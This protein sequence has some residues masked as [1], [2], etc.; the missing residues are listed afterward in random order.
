MNGVV[1]FA[2]N[3]P[4]FLD[5]RAEFLEQA[6][7]RVRKAYTLAQARHLLAEAHLHLAILDLRLEDDDDEKDIS[8]LILASEPAFRPVPKI[9]LTGFPTYHA[10][11]Q[12]LGPALDPLPP[13]VDFL[14]KQEGPEAL[15]QA[16][17]RAFTQHVRLNWDLL[18]CRDE[19]QPLSFPHLVSL[20]QPEVPPER[21]ADR[22][23]ELEDLFRK[24][25]YD[26]R[27]L[28]LGRL[29]WH[30]GQRFC[31]S[32]WARSPQGVDDPRLLVCGER[33]Q[34]RQELRQMEAL[35]PETA[36]GTARAETIHFGAVAWLL[37]DAD[38]ESMR[39]LRDLFQSGKERTLKAAL[40]S[41]LK[42]VL[43][44][45]HRRGQAIRSD[46]MALYR[47]QVGL[48]EGGL[49][50][51]EV[52]RRVEALIQGVRPLSSVKIE[53]H[54]GQ[55]TFHFP[56]EEPAIYPDPVATLYT[57]LERYRTAVVCRISPGLLTADNILVDNRQQVWLTDLAC[58]GQA[59]QWWDFVCLEALI[60]FDLSQAPDL[61]A[62]Q[63]LEQCLVRPTS[64]HERLKVQDVEADLRTGVSLIEQ[65]R[66]QAGSETGSDPLPY[67]AG[68]VAWVV[69]DMAH[70]DPEFLYTQA[71]RMRA[72]H[73]L[74]AGAMLAQRLR[75]THPLA[76]MAGALRLDEGGGV[77]IGDRRVALLDGQ[78]LELLRLLLSQ[79]GRVV[80]RRTLVESVFHEPYTP[81]DSQQ[82]SRLN[83]LVY[84]LRSKIEPNPN[85]PRYV[86]TIKNKGVQLSS[87]GK[88]DEE[89]MTSPG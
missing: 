70:Y 31:L 84:R 64:L 60:R 83:T 51:A 82:E 88:S 67:Y 35:A 33:E 28:R 80:S 30:G 78:E 38:M 34:V 18:I 19:R 13:A 14:A 9:I 75:E 6:G 16:V 81:G 44:A 37:P 62:W 32:A 45:W 12:A 4:D 86:R 22:V 89:G 20:L 50:Q 11:R 73:L 87:E 66:R 21:L 48:E 54:Q 46:L 71:E 68:L 36:Q 53:R 25:F 27:Q 65:I 77:W 52:E 29:L 43:A 15:I 58:A 69:G 74:L 76:S 40:D 49:S 63:D 7:Y 23:G 85:R 3:D 79:P 5:T 39:P 41:L 24:L 55:I 72:A 10:V 59:P 56:Q 42:G 2:D 61:L 8:G 17:E 26:Y 47:R 57:P 1:L